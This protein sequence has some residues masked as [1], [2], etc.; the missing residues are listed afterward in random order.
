MRSIIMVTTQ[1][2]DVIAV[3]TAFALVTMVVI[4]AW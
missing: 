3:C 1:T 4:G 2:L